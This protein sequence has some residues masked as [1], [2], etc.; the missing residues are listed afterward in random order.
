MR[1]IA[2]LL[3]IC[4]ALCASPSYS[5]ADLGG[6]GGSSSVAYKINNAGAVIGWAQNIFGDQQAVSSMTGFA[7][8]KL[9]ALSPFDS[10]AMGINDAGT[11]V[12]TAYMGGGQPHGILWSDLGASDLGAGIFLTGVNNLGVMIG[13]NGHAFVLAGG[14]YH[15]LG[16]LPG[17]DW[18]SASAINDAGAVVGDANVVNG[19]FRGFIWTEQSGLTQLGTFG[20]RNSHATAIN[21][22]GVVVGY[23]SLSSG[24]EH[25]FSALG[26]MMTDLGTLGGSS[27]A[28]DINDSGWIVG[29]SW[30][31]NSDN[32]HAFLYVAGV[33][34]DLN[35]LIPSDS[36]WELIAA[37][38]INNDGQIVGSGLWNGQPRAFR[39]DPHQLSSIL[40]AVPEPEAGTLAGTGFA[41]ISV[42]I[43]LRRRAEARLNCQA[44]R[45]L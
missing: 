30:P 43:W 7:F 2:L 10:F 19:D 15:D 34:I 29:Y 6:L 3:I 25:A 13:G 11:I 12:G 8:Q 9:P 45:N 31:N 42:I 22:D 44:A 14:I 38:G 5:V 23:A 35:S 28:Y 4:A 26:A 39:L 18:S 40:V 17:G 41:M 24:Y 27:F 32:P 20:G 21:R 37:Y 33:M 1:T 36:G 16:V